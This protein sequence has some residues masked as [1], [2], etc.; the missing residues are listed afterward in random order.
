MK[1]KKKV[2]FLRETQEFTILEY[3]YQE[4]E[5]DVLFFWTGVK[6]L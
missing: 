1:K 2:L 4:K 6:T 3:I 5:Q